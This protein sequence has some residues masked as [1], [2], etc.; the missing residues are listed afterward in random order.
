MIFTVTYRNRDGRRDYL[1]LDV[2]AKADVWP[3]LKKRGI[4][5]I[6]IAQGPAPK[7][8]ANKSGGITANPNTPKMAVFVA[9]A[10]IAVAVIVV[11]FMPEKK[12]VSV[13]A[14]TPS[15]V[16]SEPVKQK[17]K[18]KP[19][20]KPAPPKSTGLTMPKPSGKR[21][22]KREAIPAPPPL[23]ELQAAMTNAAPKK[24]KVA[25][26]NGVE[27]LIA[28][29]TPS[30]PGASVPPLPHITDEGLAQDLEGAMQNVIKADED[31]SEA[32]LE[33]KLIVAEAK[34][35]FR[36]L[37][38]KEGFTIT[39]YLNALRD[40]ANQDADF[41][42]EAHKMSNELYHDQTVSNEDY[43][44]YRNQINEKLRERALPEIE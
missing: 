36:E 35:E 20:V 10:A 28:L 22:E 37:R 38:E 8:A 1:E 2:P 32:T 24:K 42:A 16:K 18:P 43:I 31:D 13:K 19:A 21:I 4:S 12:D 41:L 7:S 40:Q 11:I 34:E 9:V 29:A 14:K 6:S 15:G 25:F 17:P 27:Q 5:A 23:E 39:E 26:K 30:T 33:K 44:K 3:E